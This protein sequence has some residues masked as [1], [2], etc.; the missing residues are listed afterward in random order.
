[1]DL[2][3]SATA[4]SL[5]SSE[6]RTAGTLLFDVTDRTV[7]AGETFEVSFKAAEQVKGYQF[8]MNLNGLVVEEVVPGDDMSNVNFGVFADALTTSYDGKSAGEFTVMFRATKSGKLSQMLG[9]SSRITR[10]EAYAFSGDRNTVALRFNGNMISGIG[11]E[12]YQN[13]PNP[14]VNKTFIGF[15]L[16][17]AATATLTVRDETGRTLF[18]Q[19]GDFAKGYNSIAVERELLPSVGVLYYTLETATDSAT[20]KMVQTK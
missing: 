6:D 9:V 17:E 14:F 19:K 2:N 8:T 5:M 1:G 12:L 16:P 15:H 11:F 20:K 3:A 4:N 7:K 18:T 13:Q 10:A